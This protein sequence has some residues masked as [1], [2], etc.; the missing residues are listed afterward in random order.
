MKYWTLLMLVPLTSQSLSAQEI[1]G[2]R[3]KV[4]TRTLADI[5]GNK[6]KIHQKTRDW[7]GT[8][9]TSP[10]EIIT[11]A[12]PGRIAASYYDDCTVVDRRVFFT[13][14][15]VIELND[16][17]MTVELWV[18]NQKDRRKTARE[19]FYKKDGTLK[20]SANKPLTQLV[21]KGQYFITELEDYLKSN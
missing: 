15:M 4:D 11:D 17:S 10:E 12:S 13:H 7:F 14:D 20:Q 6:E 5:P 9:F 16:N 19:Y 1:E 2:E 3:I 21:A 18:S 8:N